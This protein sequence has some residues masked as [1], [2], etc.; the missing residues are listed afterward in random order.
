MNLESQTEVFKRVKRLESEGTAHETKSAEYHRWCGEYQ[1]TASCV[2]LLFYINSTNSAQA[3]N[4]KASHQKKKEIMI[5]FVYSIIC[6]SNSSGTGPAT[7][8]VIRK[9]TVIASKIWK[10]KSRRLSGAASCSQDNK[11]HCVAPTRA[12]HCGVPSLKDVIDSRSETQTAATDQFKPG[13]AFGCQ[14]DLRRQPAE[15]DHRG[16]SL[17]MTGKFGCSDQSYWLELT[18]RQK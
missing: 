15:R 2:I 12:V 8:I 7:A 1:S 3:C 13:S 17:K 10:Q 18:R 6:F 4:V 9:L 11:T 5:R 16:L 14:R